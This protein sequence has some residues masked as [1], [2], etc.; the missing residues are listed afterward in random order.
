MLVKT[1]KLT[2]EEKTLILKSIDGQMKK[3]V[4]YY[5]KNKA[6]YGEKHIDGLKNNWLRNAQLTAFF[7]QLE[8]DG[9]AE[10]EKNPDEYYSF[11]DH[12]GD[13]YCPIT[14]P[15]IDPVILANRSGAFYYT[16]KVLGEELESIGGFVGNDFHG[17]GYDIDFYNLAILTIHKKMPV[18]FR[19]INKVVTL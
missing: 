17:S 12:C 13:C 6:Q 4:D 10:L 9:L 14:N 2:N 7:E 3:S 16:L 1:Y 5:N 11:D 15:D 8:R 18:Y 19:I